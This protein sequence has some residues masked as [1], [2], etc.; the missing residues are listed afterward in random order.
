[1]HTSLSAILPFPG[2]QHSQWTIIWCTIEIVNGN[3]RMETRMRCESDHGNVMTFVLH[4]TS[5]LDFQI[6][7]LTHHTKCKIHDSKLRNKSVWAPSRME[8]RMRFV[9]SDNFE[10][11]GWIRS[12]YVA[13]HQSGLLLRFNLPKRRKLCFLSSDWVGTPLGSKRF[14]LLL[15]RVSAAIDR[16]KS[17]AARADSH[18]SSAIVT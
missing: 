8:R 10:G 7:W 6:Q 11:K 12:T 9:L 3:S 16:S 4:D 2:I 18:S 1:M 15:Q 17:F 14:K 5:V 13:S